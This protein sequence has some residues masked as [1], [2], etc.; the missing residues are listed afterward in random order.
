MLTRLVGL[1]EATQDLRSRF[2]LTHATGMSL[3]QLR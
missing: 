3:Q 2:A 1:D